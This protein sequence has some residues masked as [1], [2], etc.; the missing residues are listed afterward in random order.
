[1]NINTNKYFTIFK[2]LVKHRLSLLVTFSGVVGY[3]I[4]QG[5]SW[6]EFLFLFAGV[7][8]M[9]GGASALNQF[10]E[11]NYDAQMDRTKTRPIPS[12]DIS[13]YNA[14]IFS[15]VLILLGTAVLS[16]NGLLPALLGLL[17]IVFYNLIYTPLKTRSPL[18]I[19]P[20]SLVGAVP[21]LIGWSSAGLN[22]THP[23]IIYIAIFMFL[24]QLPHFWLLLIM[25]GQEYEK[26]GF[27]SISKFYNTNQIKKIVFFWAGVTSIFLFFF[28]LFSIQ[29]SLILTILLIATNLA[30]IF[31]FYRLIFGKSEKKS[32]KMAFL[33]INSYLM[34]VF[35]IFIIQSFI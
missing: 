2:K 32:V 31:L 7:Y 15:I 20:G 13:P 5:R 3:L 34:L 25:L 35:V 6:S 26:A 18:S 28:P 11:R 29:L 8:F 16:F 9:S 33:A 12:G 27:S 19:I 10:Q 1:M 21:P 4:A 14:L 23:T 22:L 30:F 24:W 17:N